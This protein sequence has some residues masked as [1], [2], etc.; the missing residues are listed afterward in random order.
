[1]FN[2]SVIK[3]YGEDM[4]TEREAFCSEVGRQKD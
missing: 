1:M 4:K 3:L 2:F